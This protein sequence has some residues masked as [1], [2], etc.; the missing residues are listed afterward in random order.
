MEELCF[1]HDP[2]RDVISKGHGQFSQFCT[3]VCEER[4][5]AGSRGITLLEPLSG[6]V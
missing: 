4:T 2:C 5:R 3:G 6:N 1:L